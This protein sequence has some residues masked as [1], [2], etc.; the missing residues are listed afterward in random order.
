[1]VLKD[2][3]QSLAKDL[4]G[5]SEGY[6]GSLVKHLVWTFKVSFLLCSSSQIKILNW[7]SAWWEQI[8]HADE[9]VESVISIKDSVNVKAIRDIQPIPMQEEGFSTPLAS[10]AVHV[11]LLW[12]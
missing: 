6:S 9:V 7:A 10:A 11:P 3:I 2:Q 5:T 12:I 8:L 4:G 1:M